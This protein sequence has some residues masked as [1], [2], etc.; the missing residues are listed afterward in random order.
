MWDRYHEATLKKWSSMS[1][2][3]NT[4]HLTAANYYNKLDMI[5]GIPVVLL[6]T[7][8]ASSIL[9]SSNSDALIWTYINGGIVLLMTGISGV[10]KFLG[11]AEKQNKH[12]ISAYKYT[13][14]HMEIDTMLTLARNERNKKPI[15]FVTEIKKQILEIKKYSPEIPPWIVSGHIKKMNK[16]M[17]NTKTIINKKSN[18][19]VIENDY[20]ID[21]KHN[22]ICNSYTGELIMPTTSVNVNEMQKIYSNH[23][24]KSKSASPK[25]Y[26]HTIDIKPLKYKDDL[27]ETFGGSRKHLTQLA[28]LCNNN[29]DL[30][31]NEVPDLKNNHIIYKKIN[32]ITREN[33]IIHNNPEQIYKPEPLTVRYVESNSNGQSPDLSNQS[34]INSRDPDKFSFIN[35]NNNRLDIKRPS[36]TQVNSVSSDDSDK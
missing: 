8:S 21:D 15:D 32:D 22:I 9:T 29:S 30:S 19:F 35:G 5:F 23:Y 6:G 11:T 16:S 7:I 25:S 33:T 13:A 4:M 18:E 3:H 12:N 14:I 1:K 17:T 26:E 10:S 28:N 36:I 24:K 2:V 34:E 31:E 27:F 20:N